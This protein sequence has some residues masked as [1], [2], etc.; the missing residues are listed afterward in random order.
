MDAHDPT[1][2]GQLYSHFPPPEQ[3]SEAA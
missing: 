1:P 2:T 3:R